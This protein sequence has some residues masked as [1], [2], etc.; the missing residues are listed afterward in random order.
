[1]KNLKQYLPLAA[2]AVGVLALRKSKS[3]SGVGEFSHYKITWIEISSPSGVVLKSDVKKMKRGGVYY[4]YWID[5]NNAYA[6]FP[7]REAALNY[8]EYLKEL[9][10][11]KEYEVRLFTD[12]QFGRSKGGVPFTEKQKNE[13]FYI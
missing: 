13:V 10:L 8:I 2:I 5:P 11:Q 7:D 9:N 4:I 6:H 3:V 1:M 12:S